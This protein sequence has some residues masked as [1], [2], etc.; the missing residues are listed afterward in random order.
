MVNTF[1]LHFFLFY[2]SPLEIGRTP[3]GASVSGSENTYEVFHVGGWCVLVFGRISSGLTV[4]G[5]VRLI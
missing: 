5:S 4:G 1:D 3:G 2:V